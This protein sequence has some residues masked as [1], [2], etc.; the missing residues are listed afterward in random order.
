MLIWK[1]WGILA[2]IIPLL[3][4]LLMEIVSD[5]VFGA[6]FY[7]SASWAMPLALLLSSPVVFVVGSKLNNKPGKILIDPENNQEIELKGVHSLFWIPLQYWSAVTAVL[8]IWM[9]ASKIGT[10]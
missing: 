10:V 9:Y 7:K 5:S 6:G 8:A 3:F 2:F 4:A 1:G